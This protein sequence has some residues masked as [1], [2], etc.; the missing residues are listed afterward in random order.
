MQII[1]TKRWQRD[2]L[3]SDTFHLISSWDEQ[4]VLCLCVLV[5][6]NGQSVSETSPLLKLQHLSGP[7]SVPNF[8]R[9]ISLCEILNM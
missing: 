9:G 5:G 6:G 2:V 4:P 8:S 3:M 1:F 7:K